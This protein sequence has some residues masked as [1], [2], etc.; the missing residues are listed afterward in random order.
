M[1][2]IRNTSAAKVAEKITNMRKGLA[3]AGDDVG[4]KA[5]VY[6]RYDLYFQ[7]LQ[8]GMGIAQADA[9]DIKPVDAARTVIT[10]QLDALEAEAAL[11]EMIDAA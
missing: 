4:Q 8:E 2:D 3:A 9:E 1:S 5:D 7:G 6:T 10:K 11:G